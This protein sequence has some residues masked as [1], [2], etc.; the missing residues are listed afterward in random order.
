MGDGQ[1]ATFVFIGKHRLH[2]LLQQLEFQ[3]GVMAGKARTSPD[4]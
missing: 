1:W 3:G 2:R 4:Y